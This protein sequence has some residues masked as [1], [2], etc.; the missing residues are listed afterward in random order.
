LRH[1]VNMRAGT[2][3]KIEVIFEFLV[4]GIIIGIAEDIIAVTVVSG[5][6]ITWRVIGIIVVIAIPFAVL[7]EIIADNIDFISV[8][9]K[10]KAFFHKSQEDNLGPGV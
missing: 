10:V 8:F 7:G 6:P 4:F 3:K 2:E 1:S 5:E 9:K